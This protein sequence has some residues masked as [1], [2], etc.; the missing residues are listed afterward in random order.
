MSVAPRSVPLVKR[1]V[2]AISVAAAEEAASAALAAATARE[3]EAVL[4]RRLSGV[5]G[6]ENLLG[7]SVPE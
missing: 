1:I 2:R 3:A 4:R 5:L 6:G 7:E